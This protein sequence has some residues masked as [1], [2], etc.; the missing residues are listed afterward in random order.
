MTTLHQQQ[1]HATDADAAHAQ[2]LRAF[3]A[4]AGVFAAV[5][6]LIFAVNL[7]VNLAAGLTHWS[8]WWSAWAFIGWGFGIAVQGVVVR[9]ARPTTERRSRTVRAAVG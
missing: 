1:Q 5:M 2:Q 8:T 3:R 4:H 7:F 6:P 9:I